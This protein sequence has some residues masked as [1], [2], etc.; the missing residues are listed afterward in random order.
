MY[1]SSSELV[2]I[3]KRTLRVFSFS[4]SI[5]HLRIFNFFS[6]RL[7]LLELRMFRVHNLK[8]LHVKAPCVTFFRMENFFHLI[9][10]KLK[11]V[12]TMKLTQLFLG[13]FLQF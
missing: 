13:E 3:K 11:I 5:G 2:K 6:Q 7:S 8:V 4:M 9:W 10:H 12:I 1:D